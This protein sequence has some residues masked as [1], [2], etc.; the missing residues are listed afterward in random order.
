MFFRGLS[1]G[2]VLGVGGKCGGGN[3]VDVG[4]ECDVSVSKL[5]HLLDDFGF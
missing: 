5:F 3:G 4:A 2:G 1:F